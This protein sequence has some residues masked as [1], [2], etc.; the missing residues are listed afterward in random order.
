MTDSEI[1]IRK[2]I[3]AICD[4]FENEWS[5]D[6]PANIQSYLDRIGA[7]YRDRLL[8]SLIEVDIA[9][10]RKDNSSLSA[11][12]YTDLGEAAVSHAEKILSDDLDVTVPPGDSNAFNSSEE[13]ATAPTANSVSNSEQI[14]P[15]K[16]LQQIGEGGMGAV[17][18]AQQEHPIRRRVALKLIR[19]DMGS[20]EIIARFE[21]ERQALAMMDHQNIARVLDAGATDDGNP[22]FVMELVKG[23]TVTQYCDNNK[24]SI[25]E[26]LE[27]FVPVC[28]AVQHAHQKGIVHRDLKPSNVLVAISDGKPVPKVIDFGLAKALEHTL[29]LTDKTMFTE[30]GK[31][32]GTLQY[33]SPEQAEMNTLDVDTRTDVYSL[34]VMLYELLT[35][36][37]PLE[38][39]TV[40]KNALLQI[41]AIIRETEPPRPSHRLS[42]SGDSA[43]GVSAQRKITPAKL[44]QILRGELDWIVMKALEKDRT[45]RYETANGFAMDIERYLADEPITARPPS[46]AYRI[47]KFLK[48]HRAFVTTAATIIFLLL[49]GIIGTSWFAYQANQSAASEKFQ[50]KI[51]DDERNTATKAEKEAKDREAE[52]QIEKQNAIDAKEETEA[53]L[54]RSKY[55]LALSRFNENPPRVGEA[56]RLLNQIPEKHRQLEWHIARNQFEGSYMTLYGHTG[57]VSSVSF[58]PDQQ[59]IVSGSSDNT[60]KIWDANSGIEIKTL[61][62]HTDA[63]NSVCFSPD[64]QQIVSASADNTIKIWDAETGAIAKTL[65]GHTASVQSASFSFDGQYIVSGGWDNLIKIWNAG[66]GNEHKTLEGH[67]GFV[68]HVAFSPDGQS[69]VSRSEDGIIKIW[70]AL[71]GDVVHNLE[72][73]TGLL[74]QL[75]GFS[76]DGKLIISEGNNGNIKY[77]NAQTGKEQNTLKVIDDIE[78]LLTSNVAFSANGQ[79]IAIGSLFGAIEILDAQTGRKRNLLKGHVG[80]VN[81]VQFSPDAQRI[82]SGGT[83]TIKVWNVDVIEYS[84]TSE[85]YEDINRAGGKPVNNF[86]FSPDG[87]FIVVDGQEDGDIEI[88]DANTGELLTKINAHKQPIEVTDFSPSGQRIAT[89]SQDCDIKIWDV[90][91][92]NHS[93]TLQ[94]HANFIKSVCFS[95][96]G[97]LLVSGSDD[98]TVKIWDANSYEQLRT[99]EVHDGEIADITFSADGTK[100]ICVW[101]T[102]AIKIW[103]TETGKE[104]A[105]RDGESSFGSTVVLSN[106]GQRAASQK[107]GN[108]IEVW[109]TGTGKILTTFEGH[110]ANANNFGGVVSINFSPNG[111]RV[112]SADF[113]G[114]IKIW[115]SNSGKELFT[116]KEQNLGS[117]YVTFSGDGR[118][119]VV[120]SN[121]NT[122]RFWDTESGKHVKTIK[123]SFDYVSCIAFSPDGQ[124]VVSGSDDNSIKIWDA[125][126]GKQ[127]D[128]IKEHTDSVT[129]VTFG[130]DGQIFASGGK[131]NTIKIWNAKTGELLRTIYGHTGLPDSIS[132]DS[133]AQRVASPGFNNTIKVWDISTGQVLLTLS[134]HLD[135]VTCIDFSSD[136]RHIVSGSS[137]KTIKI[138]DAVSGENLQTLR[139]QVDAIASVSY[140]PDDQ[141]ILSLG[142]LS[143]IKI[144][145]AMTG[146]DLITLTGNQDMFSP[147]GFVDSVTYSPVGHRIISVGDDGI[148]I[149][150]ANTGE[151]LKADKLHAGIE[152]VSCICVAP[153]GQRIAYG[154]ELGL[155]EISKSNFANSEKILEGHPTNIGL[156]SISPD[157]KIIVSVSVDKTIV[158]WNAKTGEAIKKIKAFAGNFK[159]FEFSPDS[160]TFGIATQEESIVIWDAYTGQQK[161]IINETGNV[162]S[163][164]LSPDGLRIAAA[165]FGGSLKVW[166]INSGQELNAIEIKRG[167]IDHIRYSPD[168]KSIYGWQKDPFGEEYVGFVWNNESGIK[169]SNL[170]IQKSNIQKLISNDGSWMAIPLNKA[171]MLLDLNFTKTE[172]VIEY[173]RLMAQSNTE[174]HLRNAEVAKQNE[175]WYSATFHYAWCMKAQP[176]DPLNYDNLHAAYDK[177]AEEY[178]TNNK[179]LDPYLAPIVKQMLKLPRGGAESN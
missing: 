178:E 52:A 155:V 137:D 109:E 27:L 143:T 14:G 65:V 138:W 112:I 7:Q 107:S 153:D 111:E 121:D 80:S 17:W 45:R 5:N 124:Y 26:R 161:N 33:M 147:Y 20:K 76:P 146:E 170:P 6:N 108:L 169:F 62:G 44:Q 56:I 130:L 60:I 51:A 37:T 30:F 119:V 64:S 42:S 23:I 171:L 115:D 90:K 92:G 94:G 89:G 136:G 177:L 1:S 46:T 96:N 106:N 61:I 41:L 168:G 113:G 163:I 165:S 79:Y 157:D 101:E 15:Y 40:G 105:T 9:L 73:S 179:P 29:N 19:A 54:A 82:V 58:S 78:L 95:P 142:N 8:L 53:T 32:V 164:C 63:I 176:D 172:E 160:K 117:S 18:M 66:S 132:L 114:T 100:I 11:E 102:S 131:D 127:L 81:S 139:G 104:L 47:N 74:Q 43:T 97:R 91:S 159:Y 135:S 50:R 158:T 120:S 98:D 31:V 75:L 83:N 99:L 57:A 174:F 69:I 22:Y 150:D 39:E 148:K 125:N 67:Y 175:D 72:G 55:L 28:N 13:T 149:W 126:S 25:K 16:L 35:G 85:T 122:F 166:D 87:N 49:A 71:T 70:N 140:S 162:S 4:T 59:L 133:Q 34:G 48:K 2:K 145:D 144:W 154:K 77:W 93:K 3:D 103:E 128:T 167:S 86:K 10:R 116:L 110:S 36:T 68:G 12:H 84:E 38:K 129:S 141:R 173:R 156:I 123:E 151:E 24:L 21:A 152:L 118:Y 88:L 134:G